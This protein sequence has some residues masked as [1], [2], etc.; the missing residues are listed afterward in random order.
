MLHS[1]GVGVMHAGA[2]VTSQ[3]KKV[4][5]PQRVASGHARGS[6]V[7]GVRLLAC[8][9]R[10]LDGRLNLLLHLRAHATHV[11]RVACMDASHNRSASTA[12]INFCTS[13]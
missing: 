10:L 13:L 12:T 5:K 11:A 1:A 8:D 4:C 7:R 6:T 9:L 2:D 3:Q